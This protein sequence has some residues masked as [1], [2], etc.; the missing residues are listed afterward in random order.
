MTQILLYNTIYVFELSEENKSIKMGC[1]YSRL[2]DNPDLRKFRKQFEALRLRRNEVGKLYDIFKL[3][4]VDHSGTV[5]MREM[6]NFL[7]MILWKK[8][9]IKN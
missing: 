2:Y 5:S 3:L 1:S 4:D 9:K 7:C 8:Q 6:M